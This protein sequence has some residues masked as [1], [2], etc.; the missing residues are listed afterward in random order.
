[1]QRQ[2]IDYGI[3]LGTTN[4]AL[5]R[6]E[7]GRVRML[8]SERLQKDTTPSCVHYTK[9][10][11]LL[12][13]DPAYSRLT[14][15]PENTKTEF[16]RT[17]GTEVRYAFPNSQKSFTS[18]ELSAQ[19]LRTLKTSVKDDE[20]NAVVVTVPADFDQVQIEA[21]QRAAELAGFDYCELLQEPIAASLAYI[22]D[23]DVFNGHWLVFDMGGGTFDAALMN[24]DS[25]IIKV[26]DISGDNHLGGK[27]MDLL[28]VDEIIVPRLRQEFKIDAILADK[29]KRMRLENAWKRIA[30][31]A[32]IQLS[33]QSK[34]LIEP[35]DP[36]FLQD[37]EGRDLDICIEIERPQFE[38][39]IK[40]L[41]DRSL[42]LSH[43]LLKRNR[44]KPSEIKNVLLIGG[45]TFIPYVRNRI[46]SELSPNINVSMD[47]MTAVAAGAALYASTRPI[48]ASKRKREFSRLQMEFNYPNTVVENEAPFTVRFDRQ[49]TRGDVPESLFAEVVRSDEGFASGR[50]ALTGDTASFRLSLFEGVVNE[51]SVYMSD[52]AGNRIP[53]EPENFSI[54][55]GLQIS[56]PPLPHD[57]CI[58]AETDELGHTTVP[59]LS[60]GE[61]LPAIGKKV[62]HTKAPLHKGKA[63]D[64]FKI[65]VR[66]GVHSTRPIRN[67]MVGEIAIDGSQLSH[68]VAA[69]SEVEITLSMDE[70][71]RIDVSAFF[72]AIDETIKHV[73]K[74]SFRA[75]LIDQQCLV[76]ELQEELS[77]LSALPASADLSDDRGVSERQ[78]L[79]EQVVS[80]IHL[81]RTRREDEDSGFGIR[82]RLNE[83]QMR[84][85][86]L[87]QDTHWNSVENDLQETYKHAKKIV[88]I[89]GE[90]PDRE[91]LN[92]LQSEMERSVKER[93]RKSA[94]ELTE[95]LSVLRHAILVNQPGFWV[96]IFNNI[97]ITFN[98][99]KWSDGIRAND[100]LAEGKATL[101]SGNTDGLKTI[102]RS[103]WALM[104]KEEE[105]NT[106]RV[107]PD[108][109]FYRV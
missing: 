33:S 94:V 3:D 99:I 48:P 38:G 13:G 65:I 56:N 108:I 55:Q 51:F 8:K 7:K 79:R 109:P 101:K 104:T 52:A 92:R 10:G 67:V 103:L 57:I 107:R 9:H 47:P 2:K 24:A 80:L 95:K 100:L 5:C 30:E 27:N 36:S 41:V 82:Y 69:G 14:I 78:R 68:D 45:P 21:T 35:D 87:L 66:E 77:R 25:G 84:I 1:M 11:Q 12:V 19:I 88:E 75:A 49:T 102:V 59:L 46:V 93:D 34:V 61:L 98:K 62:F 31:Q 89:F 50:I 70:S 105:E 83:I 97:F 29:Y 90:K 64:S 26:V 18:E 15:D 40:P 106:Q 81:N 4:S 96:S 54:L 42:S 53:S 73:L 16:K 43:D 86:T 85:D 63:G 76:D 71:R 39:L 37:D 91:N 6:F 22:M 28:L 72:P 20:F 58:E 74:T 32:K 60:K 17:M 23:E 44:L